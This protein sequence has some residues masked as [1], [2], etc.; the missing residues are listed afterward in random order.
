MSNRQQLDKPDAD[1]TNYE[2]EIT[3][4]SV[5]ALLQQ[6]E[7]FLQQKQKNLERVQAE[8]SWLRKQLDLRLEKQVKVHKPQLPEIILWAT[9]GLIL[10]I[11]GTFIP[12]STLA[13]PWQWGEQGIQIETLQ[14]SYQIGAV[15][16]VGCVGGGTSALLSQIVYVVLGLTWLPI[17]DRGG[18][19]EYIS[20]PNFGY[21]LG[22]VIGAWICGIIAFSSKAKL[23]LLAGSSLV[24]LLVIH[25]TGII[26]LAILAHFV[27]LSEEFNSLKEGI[28][29]YSLN[30]LPGQLAV[31][32]AS[33]MIA[34]VMRKIMLS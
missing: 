21:L 4:P 5:K 12:A 11:G 31:V 15:L 22:F 3:P 7:R 10:T 24:G 23:N 9:I 20:Q 25:L 14:V 26:Y 27:G 19:W 30:P 32:C 29:T 1:I 2:W 16:L 34:Y 8:N 6:L 18:G 17:F 33:C 28:I 13:F